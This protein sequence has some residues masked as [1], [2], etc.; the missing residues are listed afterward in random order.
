MQKT[1]SLED[2]MKGYENISCNYLTRRVP[3]II[4]LDGSRSLAVSGWLTMRLQFSRRIA[5][6]L[7]S[8]CKQDFT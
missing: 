1:A 6:T 5:S 3:V 7:K 8:C 2:R 4:R